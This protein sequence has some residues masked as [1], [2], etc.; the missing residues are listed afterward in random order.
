MEEVVYFILQPIVQHIR[1][2]KA[3]SQCRNLDAGAEAKAA[4]G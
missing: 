3:G 2:I 1:E 4:E